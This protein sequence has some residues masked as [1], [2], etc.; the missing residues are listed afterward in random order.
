VPWVE[1]VA[2]LSSSGPLLAAEEMA[3]SAMAVYRALSPAERA[4]VAIDDALRLGDAAA[5]IPNA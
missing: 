4:P 1:E 3:R 2:R 5:A